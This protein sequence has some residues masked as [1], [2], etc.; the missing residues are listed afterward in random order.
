MISQKRVRFYDRLFTASL[1]AL[2]YLSYLSFVGLGIVLIYLLKTFRR[3]PLNALTRN[4]LLVISGLMGLSSLLAYDRGEAFLQLIHYLP[5]FLFFAFL[6]YVLKGAE[7]LEQLALKAVIAAIPLN[8]LAF[9]EYLLRARFIPR[10][11]QKIPMVRWLR[12]RPHEGRAML[13][14]GHPNALAAYLVILLGLGL[15]LILC[16]SLRKREPQRESWQE[17][18]SPNPLWLYI[19]TFANL[20][21]IFSS[22]SR[23]GVLVAGLQLVLVSLFARASRA[24]W[25]AGLVSMG[26]VLAGVLALG[27]GGR[28]QLLGTQTDA[29]RLVIW[30]VAI[31]LT[32]ERPWFG[33]GLGNY[34]FLYPARTAGLNLEETYVGH[35]HNLWLMLAC[36]AGILA[37]LALTAW[38]G[39]VCFQG[40]RRMVQ[41]SLSPT[42]QAVLLGYLAAFGGCMIFA[43]FDVPL[44]DGRLN[45]MS[46][47]LLSGIYTIAASPNAAFPDVATRPT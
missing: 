29:S 15:G 34:K 12:D 2:P 22:G 17:S 27:I 20:L 23:N 4:G 10:P 40:V 19:G 9:G 7:R 25:L 43:L 47:V 42:A 41:R 26:S 39:Y 32:R 11:I 14:F 37:T 18:Q 45:I 5:F 24:L 30:Q 8:L 3:S 21:G 31:D 46:W 6:P 44:F 33:W 38:V 13:T 1:A 16:H 28:S 35:P 36:E